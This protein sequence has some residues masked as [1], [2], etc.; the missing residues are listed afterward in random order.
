MWLP[1]CYLPWEE[2]EFYEVGV[3]TVIHVQE[4]TAGLAGAELQL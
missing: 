3:S 1:A 4:E 2:F